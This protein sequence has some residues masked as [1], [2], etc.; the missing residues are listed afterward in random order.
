MFGFERLRCYV[1]GIDHVSLPKKNQKKVNPKGRTYLNISITSSQ[2][3]RRKTSHKSTPSFF[4]SFFS[5]LVSQFQK[6]EPR[7]KIRIST[8]SHY[9]I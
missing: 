6:P 4:Y 7:R 9:S 5:F 1:G 2:K 3:K 8:S